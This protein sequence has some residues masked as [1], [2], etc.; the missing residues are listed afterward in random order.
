[1]MTGFVCYCPELRLYHYYRDMDQKDSKG[2]KLPGSEDDH[3]FT[4]DELEAA[5]MAYLASEKEDEAKSLAQVTALARHHPH[6]IVKFNGEG[7]IEV[8]DPTPP[9]PDDDLP[10]STNK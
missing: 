9:K 1:M 7:A 4:D 5:V 3:K 2:V 8:Q 6:K 10:S